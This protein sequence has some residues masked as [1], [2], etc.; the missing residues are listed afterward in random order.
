MVYCK[1]NKHLFQY[2]IFI[3]YYIYYFLFLYTII[4]IKF[5]AISKNIEK[6]TVMIVI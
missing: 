2:H 5:F 6:P 1:I 4:L 3:L